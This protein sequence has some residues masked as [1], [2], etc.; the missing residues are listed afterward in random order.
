MAAAKFDGP[1]E[2]PVEG[3]APIG[4]GGGGKRGSV[5]NGQNDL[6][7]DMV[8][9]T[10]D[11]FGIPSSVK[12]RHLAGEIDPTHTPQG[13]SQAKG[14]GLGSRVQTLGRWE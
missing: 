12:P 10:D 11:P 9:F 5:Q 3:Y 4:G 8:G 14:V 2:Y 13:T 1:M 7:A 6:Q